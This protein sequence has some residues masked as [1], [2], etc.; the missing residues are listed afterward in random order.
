MSDADIAQ[1]CYIFAQLVERPGHRRT[2]AIQRLV[3]QNRESTQRNLRSLPAC[4]LHRLP[5]LFDHPV[6][7]FEAHYPGGIPSGPDPCRSIKRVLS[8]SRDINRRIWLLNRLWA[9]L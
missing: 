7:T 6:K 2:V 1:L 5:I 3:Q 9:D 4:A 8:E